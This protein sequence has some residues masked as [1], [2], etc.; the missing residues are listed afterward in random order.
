MNF[1]GIDPSLTG[2]GLVALNEKNEVQYKGVFHTKERGIE[3]LIQINKY[4]QNKLSKYIPENICIEGYS[5]GS[6][7]R[8]TFSIGELGGVLRIGFYE[9]DYEYYEIAPTS[10]KKFVTGKGNCGKDLILREVYKRWGFETDCSDIADAYGLA[11]IASA[12][13]YNQYGL[14]K[15]QKDVI[16]K[17]KE[18]K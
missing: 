8:A 1:I 2:T 15:F 11:R 6:R 10:L 14:A 7:G 16:S 3:R 5:F 9:N 4:V 13:R 18:S 12:L 17:I